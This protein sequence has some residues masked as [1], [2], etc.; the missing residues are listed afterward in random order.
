VIHA[1]LLFYIFTDLHP[2]FPKKPVQ[3]QSE[4]KVEILPILRDA[5]AV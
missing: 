2:F 1:R 5:A 3:I 4:L